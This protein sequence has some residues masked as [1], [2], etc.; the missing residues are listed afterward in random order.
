[1]ALAD[2]EQQKPS[3]FVIRKRLFFNL[4]QKNRVM[5]RST[6]IELMDISVD[7]FMREYKLYLESFNGI[8]KYDEKTNN[9]LFHPN[10]VTINIDWSSGRIQPQKQHVQEMIV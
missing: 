7:K 6:L 1:M 3:L 5:R 10:N 8:I 4:I 2:T 9:F